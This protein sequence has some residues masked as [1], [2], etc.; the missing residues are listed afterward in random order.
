MYFCRKFHIVVALKSLFSFR[1]SFI[2][3]LTIFINFFG[4][5]QYTNNGVCELPLYQD[6]SNGNGANPCA[7][8]WKDQA[9]GIMLCSY[10]NC[11]NAEHNECINDCVKGNSSPS[12]WI[13]GAGN[14]GFTIC[15]I[16][17]PVNMHSFYGEALGRNIILTWETASEQNNH[18]FEVFYSENGE[19]FK[20]LETIEGA[21][22]TDK[23]Q[24]YKFIHQIPTVGIH[25]YKIRQVDFDGKSTE[26]NAIAVNNVRSDANSYF[27]EVFP[28]PVK[29]QININYLGGEFNKKITLSIIGYNGSIIN[30]KEYSDFNNYTALSMDIGDLPTGLYQVMIQH[31]D[32]I[33]TKRFIVLD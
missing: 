28:N 17:L 13:Q 25:Y 3:I 2:F 20:P 19:D 10:G 7:C 24:V 31:S 32:I 14:S 22:T 5:S 15:A 6:W 9:T 33:E 11:S 12:G 27:S 30:T 16:L 18:F 4:Y 26:T 21:G 1:F 23:S 29:T 8:K